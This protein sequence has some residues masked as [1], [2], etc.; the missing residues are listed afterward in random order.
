VHIIYFS[1]VAFLIVLG[2]SK[3]DDFTVVNPNGNE[4]KS[5]IVSLVLIEKPNL[6]MVHLVYTSPVNLENATVEITMPQITSFVNGPSSPIPQFPFT[7]NNIDKPTVITWVGNLTIGTPKTFCIIVE[8]DCNPSGKA[9]IWS[10][11]KVNGVSIKGTIKNKVFAC[12]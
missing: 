12:N 7:P 5:G 11:F 3:S 9:V 2:C 6:K 4:L 1:L 10:D 8:P